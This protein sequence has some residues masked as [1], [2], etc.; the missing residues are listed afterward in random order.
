[1][2]RLESEN[3]L[4]LDFKPVRQKS[5]IGWILGFIVW[6]RKS[7]NCTLNMNFMIFSEIDILEPN[8]KNRNHVYGE[9]WDILESQKNPKIQPLEHF[10]L[11]K[12][13]YKWIAYLGW[14][15]GY[16]LFRRWIIEFNLLVVFRLKCLFSSPKSSV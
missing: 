13:I 14:N 10:R 1:M 9:F 4:I 6:K 8:W 2:T 11:F 5:W 7:Q 3:F 16:I 12:S 15:S